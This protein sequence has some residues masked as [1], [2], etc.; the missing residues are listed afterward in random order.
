MSTPATKQTRQPPDLRRVPIFEFMRR[1]DGSEKASPIA[2]W[3]VMET[4]RKT[5]QC[6]AMLE[7][8]E[9][10]KGVL[11]GP[12]YPNAKFYAWVVVRDV[13]IRRLRRPAP[14]RRAPITRRHGSK[15]MVP[16]SV[17]QRG[18][19]Q[20]LLANAERYYR[21][22]R[23]RDTTLSDE[24]AL[25]KAQRYIDRRV[26]QWCRQNGRDPIR[27]ASTSSEIRWITF[28]RG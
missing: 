13:L 12:S 18:F 20:A 14:S 10:E 3:D 9:G 22:C 8:E 1:F 21:E 27:Y 17:G 4:A 24:E 5:G 6:L 25:R 23:Q 2:R 7:A 26:A 15:L 28:L 19:G 11:I 16:V